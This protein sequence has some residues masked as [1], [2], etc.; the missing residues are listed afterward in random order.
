M[1]IIQNLDISKLIREHKNTATSLLSA[2]LL[3]FLCYQWFTAAI[4]FREFAEYCGASAMV[5][6]TIIGLLAP[7]GKSALTKEQEKAAL[8]EEIR[9]QLKQDT[10]PTHE[11]EKKDIPCTCGNS[12]STG[13]ICVLPKV[14]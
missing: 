10:T 1:K 4:T 13:C 8:I 11:N 3:G 12:P 6:G 9:S 7:D 14:D 2:V 5:V